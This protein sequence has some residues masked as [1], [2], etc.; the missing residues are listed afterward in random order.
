MDTVRL[1]GVDTPETYSE[2]TPDEYEGV[3][4]TEAG[5]SCL[6]TEGDDATNYATSRLSGETVRLEFDAES[7]RRDYYG[8]LLAYV[9]YY[10]TNFNLQLVTDGI[11]RV[12][13]AGEFTMESQFLAAEDDAQAADIG[14]WRCQQLSSPTTTESGSS[15]AGVSVSVHEDAAGNEYENL[16]DEYV[17]LTNT[18]NTAIDISGWTIGTK[19]ILSTRSQMV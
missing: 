19:R 6:A 12:Y 10:D 7:D 14:V 3:P 11:G 17:T 4:N 2:N 18:S 16:N 8:R 1:V 15:T 13:T 9:Y 5:R